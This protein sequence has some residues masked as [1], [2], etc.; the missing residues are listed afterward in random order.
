M[1][2]ENPYRAP[3][4][5]DDIN[6]HI[7]YTFYEMLDRSL[8]ILFGAAFPFVILLMLFVPF[9]CFENRPTLKAYL[10]WTAFSTSILFWMTFVVIVMKNW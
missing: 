7:S 4:E 2:N 5:Y 6:P 1:D 9:R 10:L 3:Q 8:A